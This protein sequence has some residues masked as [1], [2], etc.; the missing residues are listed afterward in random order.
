MAV[1]KQADGLASTSIEVLTDDP[2]SGQ[3]LLNLNCRRHRV[4]T[5]LWQP[6]RRSIWYDHLE[7]RRFQPGLLLAMQY[8]AFHDRLRATT[9]LS[10]RRSRSAA[11]LLASSAYGGEIP[12]NVAIVIASHVPV[13]GKK[14]RGRRMTTRSDSSEQQVD[15]AVQVFRS[16]AILSPPKDPFGPV[17]AVQ[18]NNAAKCGAEATES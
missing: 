4:K 5:I 3:R 12:E 15:Q 17:Q 18:C 9:R 14:R 16:G 11:P 10:S 8:Q 6:D 2:L 1:R 13:V 7:K